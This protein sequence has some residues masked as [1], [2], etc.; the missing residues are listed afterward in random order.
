VAPW[1]RRGPSAFELTPAGTLNPAFG[2][3]GL[4]VVQVGS[5]S[6]AKGMAVVPGTG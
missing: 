3:G 4:A 2:S 1:F 5:G 6:I